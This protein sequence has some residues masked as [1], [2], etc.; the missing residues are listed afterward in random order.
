MHESYDD[1]SLFWLAIDHGGWS[2]DITLHMHII[3][4]HVYLTFNKSL[5]VNYWLVVSQK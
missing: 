3:I 4:V 5:V 1:P 2:V